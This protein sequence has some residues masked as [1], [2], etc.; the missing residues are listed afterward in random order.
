MIKPDWAARRP[1]KRAKEFELSATSKSFAWAAQFLLGIFSFLI[2]EL[3]VVQIGWCHGNVAPQPVD[4]TT[5]PPLGEEVRTQNPYRGNKEAVKVGNSGY[6]QN[7]ARCHGLE[8][9]SGGLAP[10]LRYLDLTP[11]TDQ[12]F[13]EKTMKGAVRNGAVHMPPFEGIL[14]QE[15][16][17]AIKTYLETIRVD[18]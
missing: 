8:G 10:D 18:K 3:V 11:D 17:W 14:N 13:M 1:K 6:L 7:C 9:I 5:L 16:V 2:V 4:T 15:A 12:Y